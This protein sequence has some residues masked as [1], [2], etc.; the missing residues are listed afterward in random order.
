M[1][2]HRGPF[3]AGFQVRKH[4]WKGVEG[5]GVTCQ[6]VELCVR[7][8]LNVRDALKCMFLDPV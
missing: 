5:E 1:R 4:F 8:A 3:F 6:P 2:S 7:E